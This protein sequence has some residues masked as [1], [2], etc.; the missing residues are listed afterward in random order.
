MAET[1]DMILKGGIVVNQDGT[2]VR[3]IGIRDGAIATV[4]TI[5]PTL[6]GT[7][8][9]CRGLHVLPGVMDTH[10]HFREPGAEHKEDLVSGS[11]AAVR[12]GVTT[13]F[14]MPNTN[15]VTTDAA[16]LADKVERG[17]G[18]AFCDFAFY[19]GASRENIDALPLLEREPGCCGIKL[20][21]G[22][23]TGDLLIEDDEGITE[24]LMSGQ[25]RVAVHSEDEYRL[26]QRERLQR[27]NDPSSHTVWRDPEAARLG[28]ERL[29]ALARAVGRRIHILHVTTAEEM[30]L[31]AAHKDI[32]S[33]EVTPQ[34]L[35][36]EATPSYTRL[37]NRA[38]MNPPLRDAPH[39]QA[40]W[41]GLATGIV[42][43][44]GSDHAPH[45]LAEKAQPY[46]RSPSGMPG[47]Q[48]L[49]P[50]MLDHVNAGRLSLER[51]VDLT[52]HGPHRI[53]QIA[54]KG[55]IA[56][57]FDADFTIVD[58][59]AK[60]TITD[61]DVESRCGWTPFD[62]LEVTGWPIG[63]IV[64]GRRVMWEDEILGTGG[65]APVTFME[66][67]GRSGRPAG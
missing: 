62:G 43:T 5:D 53:Y 66:S 33:V 54:R 11:R 6:G 18:R 32:A 13:F 51:F 1:F 46:P 64:R 9:D 3:D 22:S 38:Q 52:A 17:R 56:T 16:R 14:E 41:A 29:L 63:T 15:P 8:I 31:L 47:V 19:V 35:T 24:V 28:T 4:G 44:V 21:M 61:A 50:V 20:F 34:H 37:G 25:R 10:V 26:R 57:G 39:P 49:V 60:R 36:L 58:M 55:R 48:T 23:S 67:L 59:R 40:L 30:E 65:G 27:T 2:G 45:G 7:V 12:G 42:D